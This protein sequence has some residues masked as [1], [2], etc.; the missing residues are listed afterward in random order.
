M[1]LEAAA[2]AILQSITT[3]EVY[4]DLLCAFFVSVSALS[5]ISIGSLHDHKEAVLK[6]FEKFFQKRR[7][8]LLRGLGVDV[9]GIA[10]W[11]IYL[12][13][14][15]DACHASRSRPAASPLSAP[16][17]PTRGL[18]RR[19]SSSS[20]ASPPSPT[21]KPS[22]PLPLGKAPF[23]RADHRC[24]WQFLLRF[25]SLAP[26]A[27]SR[28]NHIPC[29]ACDSTYNATQAYNFFTHVS[30]VH[31]AFYDLRDPVPAAVRP[32][33]PFP[34]E[35]GWRELLSALPD[36]VLLEVPVVWLAAIPHAHLLAATRARIL[37]TRARTHLCFLSPLTRLRHPR[38]RR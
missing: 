19:A 8:S 9:D 28:D 23:L 22:R 14:F 15:I 2:L 32:S 35:G 21:K 20:A 1:K 25:A 18:K 29:P 17:T 3:S 6:E 31:G 12:S 38:R 33:H 11:P 16:D 37:G 34:E 4:V 13:K 36:S 7:D 24:F 10:L 30:S 5:V 26:N 27:P